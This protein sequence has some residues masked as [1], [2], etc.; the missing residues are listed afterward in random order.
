MIQ[1]FP[2]KEKEKEMVYA[3]EHCNSDDVYEFGY[4]RG[5]NRG[6]DECE[7]ACLKIMCDK[8]KEKLNEK[9]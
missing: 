6:I 3:G 1:G 7:S 5:R 2:K 8:C 9:Q 4:N